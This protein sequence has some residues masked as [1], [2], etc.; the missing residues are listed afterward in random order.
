MFGVR[1]APLPSDALLASYSRSGA[2]TDC[3][4]VSLDR[5]ASLCEFM[6][7]FYTSRIFKL[8]RWLLASFLRFPSSD[9]EA[10]MLAQGEVERFSAWQVEARRG[11]QAVLAAGRTRSW[12]MVAPSGEL[13][14]LFFGS[15]IVPRRHGG[16]GWPFNI[17]LTFHK[18]YSRI[19]LRAA[20]K[21]LRTVRGKNN[22]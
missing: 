15:A 17:L 14:T 10:K 12:L 13:T 4:S 3:Y 5:P 1:S 8:E 21:K 2:Y 11:D 18:V 6:E 16:L 20:A 9:D 19:L 22:A 7:A